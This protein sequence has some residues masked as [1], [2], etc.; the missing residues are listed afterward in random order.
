[1]ALTLLAE[2][3]YGRRATT[4]TSMSDAPKPKNKGPTET[5]MLKGDDG[6]VDDGG[7]Q[8]EEQRP[9]KQKKVPKEKKEMGEAE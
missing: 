3:K 2:V 7:A 1:M 6:D 5:P 4:A 9:R 8:A